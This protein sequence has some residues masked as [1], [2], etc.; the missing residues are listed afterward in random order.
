MNNL[1]SSFQ[2][3]DDVGNKNPEGFCLKFNNTSFSRNVSYL[4]TWNL[5]TVQKFKTQKEIMIFPR[6]F[7]TQMESKKFAKKIEN[8]FWKPNSSEIEGKKT[9]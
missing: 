8:S 3:S 7:A 6:F 1:V 5:K 4:S 2:H 9:N